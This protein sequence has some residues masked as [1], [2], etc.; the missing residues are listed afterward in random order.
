MIR[1]LLERDVDDI[2]VIDQCSTSPVLLRYLD[3]L[4]AKFTVIRLRENMGPHWFFMSGFALKLPDFFAY[5][6]P[7]V[8]FTDQMPKDFLARLILLSR[9]IGASKIGVA[10]D[11]SEPEKMRPFVISIGGR[12]YSIPEWEGQF[13]AR[14]VHHPN[15]QLFRAP[16]DTTFAVYNRASFEGS[17]VKYRREK[18]YD[19]MDTPN[20]YRVAGEF[21]S[22]HVPWMKDDPIPEEELAMYVAHR[23][24]VHQY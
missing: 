21:T 17:I 15:Y 6:D 8:R 1:Q 7:D 20:S 16:V 4:S 22:V 5:T 12:T 2:T 23:V 11:V 24:D 10:L 13:W 9:E 14:R 18:V 3:E 19:C